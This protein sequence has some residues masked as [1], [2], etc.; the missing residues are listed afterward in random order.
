VLD[1]DLP[2][3][4]DV[5]EEID[6]QKRA[7]FAG[8]MPYEP[9]RLSPPFLERTDTPN[10]LDSDFYFIR[11]APKGS[12]VSLTTVDQQSPIKPAQGE[13]HELAVQAQAS[14]PLRDSQFTNRVSFARPV[15]IKNFIDLSDSAD[16]LPDNPARLE[17]MSDI[18][19]EGILETDGGVTAKPG[20]KK[21]RKRAARPPDDDQ[22]GAKPQLARASKNQRTAPGDSTPRALRAAERDQQREEM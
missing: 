2:S 9:Y 11:L 8:M 10:S 6:D 5:W 16:G 21:G 1:G 22:E 18:E 19:S 14:T 13:A 15:K 3:K 12:N 17:A 7:E 4:L 20:Q